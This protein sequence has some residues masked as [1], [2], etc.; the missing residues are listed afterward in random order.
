[1]NAGSPWVTGCP[2]HPGRASSPHSAPFHPVQLNAIR[3]SVT[4]AEGSARDPGPHSSDLHAGVSVSSLTF[5]HTATPPGTHCARFFEIFP[6]GHPGLPVR[7]WGTPY[8]TRRPCP[9]S[10]FPTRCSL[11]GPGFLI[12]ASLTRADTWEMSLNVTITDGNPRADVEGMSPGL[13]KQS[14]GGPGGVRARHREETASQRQ[15]ARRLLLRAAA[16]CRFLVADAWQGGP[17]R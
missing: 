12:S 17:G 16:G 15:E 4:G 6:S 5:V 9:P 13:E 2:P 8:H 10:A 11:G 3:P 7:V 1:M 14:S